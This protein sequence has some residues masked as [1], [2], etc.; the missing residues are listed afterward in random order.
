MKPDETVD[1]CAYLPMSHKYVQVT[2]HLWLPNGN[3]WRMVDGK[4]DSRMRFAFAG[5]DG[6]TWLAQL[7][8]YGAFCGWLSKDWMRSA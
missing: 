2:P 5:P 7:N 3:N 8:N 1:C 6:N 4:L